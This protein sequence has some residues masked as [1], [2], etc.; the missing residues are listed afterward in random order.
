M[1]NFTV[2]VNINRTTKIQHSYCLLKE[3]LPSKF[4]VIANIAT[5]QL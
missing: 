2:T 5:Y 4:E 3:L 1:L